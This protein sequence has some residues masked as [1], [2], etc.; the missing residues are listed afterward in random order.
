MSGSLLSYRFATG[1]WVCSC[2]ALSPSVGSS[3]LK[4]KAAAAK[5]PSNTGFVQTCPCCG[6][7]PHIPAFPSLPA[8]FQPPAATF[9]FLLLYIFF[10]ISPESCLHFLKGRWNH[11][12][13]KEAFLRKQVL[14]DV[15]PLIFFSFLQAYLREGSDLKGYKFLHAK[16]H[17]IIEYSELGGTHKDHWIPTTDPAQDSPKNN[18]MYPRIL[19]NHFLSSVRLGV[20]PT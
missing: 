20:V 16:D 7:W 11:I 17:W 10:L 13:S 5:P 9:S 12:F 14:S 4:T 15:R 6:F 8:S 3:S 18:T 2:Q 1:K 19:S